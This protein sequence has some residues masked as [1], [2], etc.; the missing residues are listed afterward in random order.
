MYYLIKSKKRKK[1]K[2]DVY[3]TTTLCEVVSGWCR[4]C[5]KFREDSL[6]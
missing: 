4:L 3:L 1:K 6:N 5:L 2:S